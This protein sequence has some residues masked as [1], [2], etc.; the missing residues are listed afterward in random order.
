ME[1]LGVW[2]VRTVKGLMPMH[3]D[4][5]EINLDS[6]WMDTKFD[7]VDMEDFMEEIKLRFDIDVPH[8][9]AGGWETLTDTF[10]YI[11]EKQS[12]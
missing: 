10:D 4:S 8:K 2:I 7:G 11:T 5:S 6:T 12:A 9:I 3:V 1:P